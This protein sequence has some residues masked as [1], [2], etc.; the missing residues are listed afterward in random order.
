MNV[1][2]YS[3]YDHKTSLKSRFLI[4]NAKIFTNTCNIGVGSFSIWEGWGA[5]VQK[6]TSIL[7]GGGYCKTYKH[8]CIHT[9]MYAQTY[10]SQSVKTNLNAEVVKILLITHTLSTRC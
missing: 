3:S 2:F 4:E 9:Y 6:S 10:E 7:G 8:A 5:S 1:R